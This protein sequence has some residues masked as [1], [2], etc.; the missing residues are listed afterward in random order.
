MSELFGDDFITITDEDIAALNDTIRFLNDN[1][2]FRKDYDISESVDR[3]FYKE[4]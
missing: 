2:I 4:D 1:K 3:S